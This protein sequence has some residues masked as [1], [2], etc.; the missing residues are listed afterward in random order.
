MADSLQKRL[1]TVLPQPIAAIAQTDFPN[2]LPRHRLTIH[3]HLL[4]G[5]ITV[6]DRLF[7]RSE[8]ADLRIG[9][10]AAGVQRLSNQDLRVPATMLATPV[11]VILFSGRSSRTF[12]QYKDK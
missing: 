1:L 10:S 12:L 7:A 3:A 8:G 6:N 11:N 5:R 4:K 2:D 9:A